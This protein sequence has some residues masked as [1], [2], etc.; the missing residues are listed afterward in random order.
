MHLL[1]GKIAGCRTQ[2]V[3]LENRF[4]SVMNST[5]SLMSIDCKCEVEREEEVYYLLKIVFSVGNWKFEVV[6][7]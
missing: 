3:K 5:H 6:P 7:S 1:F 4:Q 2:I